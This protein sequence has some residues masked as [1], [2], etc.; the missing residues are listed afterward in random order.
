MPYPRSF[1]AVVGLLLLIMAGFWPFY[2]SRLREVPWELHLHGATASLWVLLLLFQTRSIHAGKRQAHRIAG[3]ASLALT[4][5][6]SAGLVAA[7]YGTARF[8]HQG[9]VFYRAVGPMF[10]I[11]TAITLPAFLYLYGQALRHRTQPAPHAGYMLG[12]ALLLF[13]APFARILVGLAPPFQIRGIEDFG[14][15]IDA[16]VAAT[17]LAAFIA[18]LLWLRDRKAARPFAEVAVILSVQ[19]LLVNSLSGSA[20][21]DA[22]LRGFAA[23]PFAASLAVA[24]MAGLATTWLGWRAIGHG[25]PTGLV[26]ANS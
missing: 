23:A 7:L 21:V 22:G 14:N 11:S 9:D 25:L 2:W 6:I 5:F 26:K 19:A 18:A 20:I 4:P 8:Y 15:L 13:Q 16:V 10:A 24:F 3:R 1:F 12:T 17:V